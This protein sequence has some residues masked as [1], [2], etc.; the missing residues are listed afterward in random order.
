M[1]EMALGQHA[2]PNRE[3]LDRLLR[4]ETT[5]DRSRTRAFDQ[6]ERLQRRRGSE[7]IRQ[8]IN[9]IQ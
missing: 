6:L 3:A 4:Y 5:I 9:R 2:I 7:R 1:V 8:E